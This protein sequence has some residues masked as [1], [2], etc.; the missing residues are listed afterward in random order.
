MSRCWVLRGWRADG[1]VDELQDRLSSL[2]MI[3]AEV[4]EGTDIMKSEFDSSRYLLVL[5]SMN[6][7]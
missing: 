7:C 3:H 4:L 1:R 2:Q 6:E 5:I